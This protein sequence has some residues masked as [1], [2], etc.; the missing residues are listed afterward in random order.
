M[1]GFSHILPWH[2]NAP[3]W[4]SFYSGET[5]KRHKGTISSILLNMLIP[6]YASL[7]CFQ[8][9][10][11][12]DQRF[13]SSGLPDAKTNHKLFKHRLKAYK[14][15]TCNDNILNMHWAAHLWG[16]SAS[17]L[18]LHIRDADHDMTV[19]KPTCQL[20]LV[21]FMRTDSET[22]CWGVCMRARARLRGCKHTFTHRQ[23][24][25]FT[26]DQ[27]STVPTAKCAAPWRKMSCPR[28]TC[29]WSIRTVTVLILAAFWH[30][31]CATSK[32]SRHL[33][34]LWHLWI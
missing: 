15:K 21:C 26:T 24:Q 2:L 13:L 14:R 4:Q 18:I 19:T 27:G 20:L 8:T 22:A 29:P 10:S 1:E 3:L 6:G 12:C 9:W 5:L 25:R 32:F 33:N 17:V 23:W 34:P 28:N 16:A 30:A 7:C 11:M 31:A